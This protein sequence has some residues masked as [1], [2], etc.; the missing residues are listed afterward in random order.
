[1]SGSGQIG[2]VSVRG[3]SHARENRP[4][5]DAVAFARDGA[6]C[7][8]A[9]A[10]GH[11]SAPHYRSDRGSAFAVAAALEL[12]RDRAADLSRDALA[13]LATLPADLVGAWRERVEADIRVSPVREAPGF[14][15]LAV[16]GSTCLAAAIG[17]DRALFLQIGDGDLIVAVAS[18]DVE[19]AID[20]KSVV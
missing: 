10:D 7:F 4:N 3:S 18:G 6:W 13:V 19:R 11:G 8:I 1:M 17:P 12:L 14:E 20:R 9:V 5:Q 2:G 16:Y 15:S